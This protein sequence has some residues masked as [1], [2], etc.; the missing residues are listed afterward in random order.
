MTTSDP[1]FRRVLLVSVAVN[2]LLAAVVASSWLR[3]GGA[4]GHGSGG[5]VRLP[6]AD[7][8]AQLLPEADRA[9]V[10]AA[11]DRHRDGIRRQLA[12]LWEAR[13]EVRDALDADPYDGERTER[14]LA[15]LRER[16][17][18][19]A[20][21]VHAL[22]VDLA[23]NASRDGRT[24]LA[25]LGTTRHGGRHRGNHGPDDRTATEGARSRD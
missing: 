2:V 6:R 5:S 8:L 12:P 25:K 22:L 11:Y 9:A 15:T 23:A 21:A 16:E 3:H 19:L 1:R 18:T 24:A 20:T 10:R 4:R 7:V 14:A 17:A 13:R